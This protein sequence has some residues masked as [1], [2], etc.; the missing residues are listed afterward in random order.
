MPCVEEAFLH[1]P[2]QSSSSELDGKFYPKQNLE[3]I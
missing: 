3:G 1:L 2:S